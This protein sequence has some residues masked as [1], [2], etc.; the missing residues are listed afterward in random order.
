MTESWRTLLQSNQIAVQL[1]DSGGGDLLRFV[2][3]QNAH[4]SALLSDL[5]P[6]LLKAVVIGHNAT[7]GYF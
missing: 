4:S 3:A 5:I 7:T 6:E 2:I 1:S